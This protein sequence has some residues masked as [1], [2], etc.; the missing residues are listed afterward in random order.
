[1]TNFKL[2]WNDQHNQG[3]IHLGD[4][5]SVDQMASAI[6]P[7]IDELLNQ[8]ADEDQ[9]AGIKRGDISFSFSDEIL[10]TVDN[11][12]ALDELISKAGGAKLQPSFVSYVGHHAE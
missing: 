4:F 11:D 8:C 7:A 3:S 6:Q 10:N 1:M 5:E 12:D 2:Y 9:K